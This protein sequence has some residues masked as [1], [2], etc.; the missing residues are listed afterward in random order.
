MRNA[1]ESRIKKPLGFLQGAEKPSALPHAA[2]LRFAPILRAAHSTL[3]DEWKHIQLIE[4]KQRRHAPLDTIRNI[5][6]E[7]K[8]AKIAP[9]NPIRNLPL[10]PH[11]FPHLSRHPLPHRCG[12]PE[13]HGTHGTR[14][15][16]AR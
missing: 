10:A 13:N 5:V 12:A 6:T 14:W 2:P 15:T 9:E 3:P 7:Q 16:N 11:D 1:S 8:T 4:N